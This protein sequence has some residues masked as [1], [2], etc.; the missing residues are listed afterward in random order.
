MQQWKS[1]IFFK[2]VL[3]GREFPKLTHPANFRAEMRNWV[4]GNASE[5]CHLGEISNL[6]A[7]EIN[8]YFLVPKLLMKECRKQTCGMRTLLSKYIRTSCGTDLWSSYREYHWKSLQTYKNLRR[9]STKDILIRVIRGSIILYPPSSDHL[10]KLLYR[11]QKNDW[12][13]LFD[14]YLTSFHLILLAFPLSRIT[15]YGHLHLWAL[16]NLL[17]FHIPYHTEVNTQWKF[18]CMVQNKGKISST[19][20][21]PAFSLNLQYTRYYST[22]NKLYKKQSALTF[23]LK[24][25]TKF[26]KL[27][28]LVK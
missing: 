11:V 27:A 4:S 6:E 28:T 17:M 14:D 10:L 3:V 23:A 18:L 12:W 25:F 1:K 24:D 21:Y 20:F 22:C 2:K 8:M 19:I 15:S 7:V 9:F 26:S 13:I 5:F 16:C